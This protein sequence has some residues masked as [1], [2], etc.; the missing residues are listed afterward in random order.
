MIFYSIQDDEL[1]SPPGLLNIVRPF[2]FIGIKMKGSS[3]DR[4]FSTIRCLVVIFALVIEG[5]EA[6]RT[7]RLKRYSKVRTYTFLKCTLCIGFHM[8]RCLS[9]FLYSVE[10]DPLLLFDFCKYTY[11]LII[12]HQPPF[13]GGNVKHFIINQSIINKV[14]SNT[15]VFTLSS[16]RI[17]GCFH[18]RQTCIC[19]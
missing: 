15:N 13:Y 16:N 2:D 19:T 8:Q 18:R 10:I 11:S 14:R 4:I 7:L 6:Y 5:L 3:I 17:T 1:N 9:V 12:L